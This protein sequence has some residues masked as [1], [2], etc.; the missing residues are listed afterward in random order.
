MADITTGNS[1]PPVRTND[2]AGGASTGPVPWQQL[3]NDLTQPGH[4]RQDIDQDVK[5]AASTFLAMNPQASVQDFLLQ[6][7]RNLRTL[8]VDAHAYNEAAQ[9]LGDVFQVNPGSAPDDYGKALNTFDLSTPTPPGAPPVTWQTFANDLTNPGNKSKDQ[10]DSDLRTLANQ[11]KSDNPDANLNDFFRLY[12]SQLLSQNVDAHDYNAGAQYIGDVFHVDAGAA[13]TA[14][15][16][17]LTS[18]DLSGASTPATPPTFAASTPELAQ[19]WSKLANDIKNNQP[20]QDDVKA[21][22]KAYAGAHLGAGVQ[23]F[24]K[25]LGGGLTANSASIASLSGSLTAAFG[26]TGET[27][28]TALNSFS[29][30]GA[31]DQQAGLSGGATPATGSP[32]SPPSTVDNDFARLSTDFTTSSSAT[33]ADTKTAAQDYMLAHPTAKLSDFVNDANKAI[34]AAG[35]P[36]NALNAPSDQAGS[37]LSAVLSSSASPVLSTTVST[38]S[39]TS[40]GSQALVSDWRTI[41]SDHQTAAAATTQQAHIAQARH[42]FLKDNSK[43]TEGDF[44]KALAAGLQANGFV[45]GAPPSTPGTPSTGAA[46]STVVAVSDDMN[47]IVTN[48]RNNTPPDLGTAQADFAQLNPNA[49]VGDFYNT[50]NASLHA[51][52]ITNADYAPGSQNA[53]TPLS[54][55]TPNQAAPAA[56]TPATPSSPD[57]NGDWV[58]AATAFKNGGASTAAFSNAVQRAADDYLKLHPQATVKDFQGDLTKGLKSNGVS[59]PPS[60][61]TN[62]PDATPLSHVGTNTWTAGT[63]P[64]ASTTP[65]LQDHD[66]LATAVGGVISGVGQAAAVTAVLGESVVAGGDL[67][68]G[69][70]GIELAD[71]GVSAAQATQI[72]NSLGESNSAVSDITHAVDQA[73]HVA[74]SQIDTDVQAVDAAANDTRGINPNT[75]AGSQEA[76]LEAQNLQRELP[77]L[78]N[79]Q[80]YVQQASSSLEREAENWYN[81]GADN[82]A[83]QNPPSDPQAVQP[84]PGVLQQA[85]EHAGLSDDTSA[86]AA[87]IFGESSNAG[88]GLSTQDTAEQLADIGVTPDQA[89]QIGTSIGESGSQTMELSSD[90]GKAPKPSSD[91]ISGAVKA[92]KDLLGAEATLGSLGN[93]AANSLISK[94]ADKVIG[95]DASLSAEGQALKDQLTKQAVSLGKR[96]GTQILQSFTG[97]NPS[98]ASAS[99]SG[100]TG[101]VSA[102]GNQ[103]LL[104]DPSAQPADPESSTGT[105]VDHS[106]TPLFGKTGNPSPTDVSQGTLGDCWLLSSMQSLAQRNPQWIKDHIKQTSPGEYTVTLFD[107]NGKETPVQVDAKLLTHSDGTLASGNKAS[108]LWP[109]LYE[110]A[111]AKLASFEGPE[112]GYDALYAGFGPQGISMITGNTTP[113]FFQVDDGGV[114]RAHQFNGLDAEGNANPTYQ[115]KTLNMDQLSSALDYADLQNKPV[116]FGTPATEEVPT[117]SGGELGGGHYWSVIGFDPGSGVVSLLDPEAGGNRVEKVNL[118]DIINSKDSQF[119]FEPQTP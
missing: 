98:G 10:I 105:Q 84:T 80:D 103:D 50:I 55:A 3:A 30:V 92:Q 78:G 116:L 39:S 8:N 70:V 20:T 21:A 71:L 115:D 93:D 34:Q 101:S 24:V 81:S 106:A 95:P 40:L 7:E 62:L 16:A 28:S 38:P 6:W 14:F 73:P 108:V 33:Y 89:K 107:Q 83:N 27:S 52:G 72:F 19:Y 26:T 104:N 22:A 61:L 97:V 67:A 45:S 96:W 32:G 5:N 15:S 37:Q 18:F 85:G 79:N 113:N 48:T 117:V 49:T 88:G 87:E 13:S 100:A 42:D 68:A 118:K 114:V 112:S 63:A 43:A 109:A 1:A 31:A 47:S 56:S 74:Q 35:G 111:A 2:P 23:D 86:A 64:S 91:Q 94:L 44:Q 46:L 99:A 4:S 66:R 25:E 90:V 58:Q 12:Q 51:Q 119:V 9:Y 102:M 11:F 82:P 29:F 59:N 17:G 110:K 53:S 77:N 76:Q 69:A 36:A 75:Q 41:A 60:S 54:K 57:I 65:V